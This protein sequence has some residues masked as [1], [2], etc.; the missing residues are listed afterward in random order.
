MIH[1]T[2]IIDP[3]AEIGKDV[4]IGPYTII[5]PKV[6]IGDGCSIGSH[7]VIE[8][9]VRM[10]KMNRISSFAAVGGPP[11]DLKFQGE[12]T[13]VE[14]GDNNIIREF[15][16]VHRG[17]PDGEGIT[18]V[19]DDN[20]VMAYCHIAHDCHIGNRV[21]MA[22]N[23]TLAG[24]VSVGD[25]AVIGGLTAVHQFVRI[26]TLS[27]IGGMSGVGQDVPP[28][29]KAAPMRE[30]GGHALFGLN[31]VGLRRNRFSA[32]TIAALKKAYTFLFRS[33]G[34]LKEA[35][36]KVEAEVPPLAEVKLLLEFVRTSTRGVTR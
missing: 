5:G 12:D 21:V 31:L 17:A 20:M 18:R 26:G 14:I 28:Y 25:G 15:A 8:S 9:H 3:G 11:Q 19:G 32:E 23:A 24:H 33:E 27:M 16:T 36:A 22:N 6:V 4:A 30:R 7:A 34:T 29:V 35:I 10:G 2:A 13:W 1:P